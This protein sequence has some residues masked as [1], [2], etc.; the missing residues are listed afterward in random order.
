MKIGQSWR[1]PAPCLPP[2][3][4]T[5][6]LATAARVGNYKAGSNGKTHMGNFVGRFVWYELATTDIET[7]K[8]FY[9]RVVGWGTGDASMPGSTYTLFT[10]G[11]TPTAGLMELP[12]HARTPDTVPQWIG[13]VGVPDVDAVANLAGQLGGTIHVPPTDVPNVSR[14]SV[15]ADREA[16]TLALVKG[17]DN[18]EQAAQPGAPGHVGWHEL[19]ASDLEGAFTFYS[20]LLGW[21][22]TDVQPGSMGIYQLLSAGTE[23][24]GGMFS[25]PGMSLLS[26]WLYYFNVGDIETAAKR[27][28]A[29]GGQILY[30]PAV[31]QGGARIVHCTDPQGAIFALIDRR[32]RVSVGCYSP[33]DSVEGPP[34]GK[35]R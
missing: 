14:F 28:Q 7:A 15:I 32:V 22:K 23:T 2:H 27:V 30:G 17:R 33:R 18:Q 3:W 20:K 35:S 19:L 6:P 11:G 34:R 8:A 16:A 24:I 12:P 25:R 1:H 5:S 13:Y 10:A 9:A 31:V 4:R 21:Q 26:L 29:G